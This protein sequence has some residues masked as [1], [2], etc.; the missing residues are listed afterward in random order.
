MLVRINYDV[1]IAP[2]YCRPLPCCEFEA[3]TA[4]RSPAGMREPPPINPQRSQATTGRRGV[5]ISCCFE[6]LSKSVGVIICWI[7]LGGHNAAHL[8]ERSGPRIPTGIRSRVTA[9]RRTTTKDVF[10]SSR[11]THDG[12][13]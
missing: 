12:A 8:C 13:H 4:T 6:P 10:P 1:E 9:P 11:K 7:A 5:R 3:D 2:W